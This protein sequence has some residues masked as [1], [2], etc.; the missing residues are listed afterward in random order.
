M[1]NII[2]YS[3][4]SAIV[5]FCI[6]DRIY[7]NFFYRSDENPP[8]S[9]GYV[10]DSNHTPYPYIAF[11]DGTGLLGPDH[12]YRGPVPSKKKDDT[13]RIF[14]LGGSA[15]ISS[16]TPFSVF[17][18]KNLINEGYKNIKVF[19]FGVGSSIIYQDLSRI[20]YELVDY[21]PNLVIFYNGYNEFEHPNFADPRPKYPFNFFVEEANPFR[22]VAPKD[23]PLL[24]LILY[25]S[26]LFRRIFE[27]YFYRKLTNLEHLKKQVGYGTRKWKKEIADS[28]WEYLQKARTLG[29]AFNFE[30]LAIF[31]PI[32]DNPNSC[33]EAFEYLCE[34]I[35]ENHSF[36]FDRRNLFSKN[37]ENVFMDGVH[38]KEE[39][40]PD[41]A[42][43]VTKI[44][45]QSKLLTRQ[46]EVAF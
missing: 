7:E 9:N 36:F 15:T 39:Y 27:Q 32:R 2:I 22:I 24:P 28:Y 3:F 26:A 12:G 19:N 18:E 35:S 30:V 11:K 1:R 41:V 34:R 17:L 20:L 43:E 10:N 23:Y 16:D 46:I 42:N 4:I 44:I 38:I 37:K 6:A 29:K 33:E 14:I 21:H 31:Q 45:M 13:F 25:K 40:E 8:F 5:T